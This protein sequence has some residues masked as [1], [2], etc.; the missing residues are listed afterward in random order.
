[1]NSPAYAIFILSYNHPELT[2]KT[3]QSVLDL[4]FPPEQIYLL[5]NGSEKKFI[6]LLKQTFLS[7]QHLI[8]E[9]N[10]GY[11]GGANAGLNEVFKKFE[12]AFFLTN[13]T[14]LLTLPK[15]IDP[16]VDLL[17][18]TIFKR[19]T[20]QLDS[21]L[22][23]L[24]VK[25]G[26]LKHIKCKE[27]VALVKPHEKIYAPGTAFGV[28]KKCFEFLN[29][30]DETFHTYWEDVDFGIRATANHFNIQSSS[31]FQLR[32]KIGKTCH[33]DRYYT[34]YL[35]QRNRRRLMK[36]HGFGGFIFKTIYYKD[37]LKL[38]YRIVFQ[39]KPRMALTFWWKALYE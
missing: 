8:L 16:A 12:W 11:S 29:G 4:N 17:A 24:N 27:D 35:F 31:E 37:M 15:A 3:V 20:E 5:H 38:L 2:Q 33:K 23:A 22:G 1:V 34:L 18:P 28:S 13:D 9:Q 6:N 26:R 30:F 25:N 21:I 19:K 10:K 36:K 32:H 39:E 7:I 14:E